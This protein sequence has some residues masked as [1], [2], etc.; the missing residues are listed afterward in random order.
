[1]HFPRSHLAPLLVNVW[2][3]GRD[4][5]NEHNTRRILVQRLEG[6][7]EDDLDDNKK[8]QDE[9]DTSI[10]ENVPVSMPMGVFSSCVRRR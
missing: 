2:T 4:Y 6:V 3:A 1:M 8:I 7:R 9:M 10:E 5:P